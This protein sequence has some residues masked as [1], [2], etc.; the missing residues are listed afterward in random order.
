[1][2]LLIGH[3][4]PSQANSS[5]TRSHTKI[6]LDNRTTANLWHMFGFHKS[7]KMENFK[8]ANRTH[9]LP[10]YR[11]SALSIELRGDSAKFICA[12]SSSMQGRLSCVN[13]DLVAQWIERAP[14]V[15][16]VESSIPV[17]G[18]LRFFPCSTLVLCLDLLIEI[19]LGGIWKHLRSRQ[20][21]IIRW[22]KLQHQKHAFWLVERYCR[23]II[24]GL[25]S[26]QTPREICRM[27]EK[28]GSL[29]KASEF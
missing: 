6:A 26:Y 5:P 16:E 25:S 12:D 18:V 7:I 4:I 15:W 1:M 29:F 13:T 9:W 10:K 17:A 22:R 2:H 8:D 14:G 24:Q 28:H 21:G 27:S 3:E 11:A 23:V 20:N 19:Y